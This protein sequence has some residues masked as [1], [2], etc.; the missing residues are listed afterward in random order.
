MRKMREGGEGDKEEPGGQGRRGGCVAL[1]LVDWY[2]AEDKRGRREKE[3]KETKEKEEKDLSRRGGCGALS[4][5]ARL[6]IF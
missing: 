3:K 4:G 5:V 2:K 1:S 6:P